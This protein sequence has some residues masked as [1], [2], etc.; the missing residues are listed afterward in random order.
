MR[1]QLKLRMPVGHGDKDDSVP[2]TKQGLLCR[3][4]YAVLP[5][6]E[7]ISDTA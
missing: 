4:W 5:V 7:T 1:C 2:V 6:G 3:V